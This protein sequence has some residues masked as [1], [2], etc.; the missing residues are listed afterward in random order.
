MT[1]V[2]NWIPKIYE[3]TVKGTDVLN[4]TVSSNSAVYSAT[5]KNLFTL[6]YRY[7]DGY[8][9]ESNCANALPANY[10][11]NYCAQQP[12]YSNFTIDG[13][14]SA[15]ITNNAHSNASVASSALVMKS[16]T[17]AVKMPELNEA[18]RN[19]TLYAKLRKK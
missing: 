7:D 9:L 6:Y 2:A 15:M 16:D 10:F 4:Y 18:N 5:D 3:I 13:I 12:G 17:T 19:G 8:Y 1:L 14:Y 11:A